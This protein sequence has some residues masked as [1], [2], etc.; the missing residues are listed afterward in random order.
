[1]GQQINLKSD[2]PYAWESIYP[3][4]DYKF[5]GLIFN[6]STSVKINCTVFKKS[7]NSF[8]CDSNLVIRGR[9]ESGE[10]TPLFL[11]EHNE[12]RE[13]TKRIYYAT[14]EYVQEQ[15]QGSINANY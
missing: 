1:M 15:I 2:M 3:S 5:T 10:T 7:D 8:Y 14:T 6:D 12:N 13:E 4:T 11:V 9:E